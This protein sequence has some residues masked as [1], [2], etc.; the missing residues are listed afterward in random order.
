MKKYILL[1]FFVML[2]VINYSSSYAVQNHWASDVIQSFMNQGFDKIINFDTSD[3][4]IAKGEFA[5]VVNK[6]LAFESLDLSLEDSLKVATK[7]GYFQ[8]AKIDDLISREE[9]CVVFQKF[10]KI[11]SSDDDSKFED[12]LEISIWAKS[13]VNTLKK[14]GIVI[15]YPDGEFKPKRMLT[16]A[17]FITMLSR[18]NGTGGPDEPP[19]LPLVDEEQQNLEVGVIVFKD[20]EI[21]INMIEDELNLTSGDTI[22]LSFASPTEDEVVNVTIGDESIAQFDKDLNTL[23]ALASGE[24][25]ITF[26]TEDNSFTNQIKLNIKL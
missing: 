26:S 6:Y 7:Q 10:L 24:T 22:L 21:K 23:T 9:A 12:D 11:D 25:T 16:K 15:G 18:I 19:L 13:S 20:G 2:I 8:N 3:L 4:D 1:T 5:F 14:L 17:E